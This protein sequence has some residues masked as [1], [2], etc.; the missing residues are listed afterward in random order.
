MIAY[1]VTIRPG[2]RERFIDSV[3]ILEENAHKRSMDLINEFARCGFST[4]GE[5]RWAVKRSTCEIED[6]KLGNE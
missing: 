3:W 4:T 5:D 1:M 6:A 2:T